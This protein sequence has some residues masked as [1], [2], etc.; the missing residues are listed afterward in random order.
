[1]RF[2]EIPPAILVFR[3]EGREA[4]ELYFVALLA[5]S[6]FIGWEESESIRWRS[7]RFGPFA[8]R[9]DLFGARYA[10]WLRSVNLYQ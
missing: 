2:A 1:V 3:G 6:L 9:G 5:S 10:E 8:D 7:P 4:L